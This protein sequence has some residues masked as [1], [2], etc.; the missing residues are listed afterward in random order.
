[1]SNEL[2]KLIAVIPEPV[3]QKK[4]W[5]EFKTL[6][7]KIGDVTGKKFDEN[8]TPYQDLIKELQ[9]TRAIICSFSSDKS[10]IIDLRNRI[11]NALLG[12]DSVL[13]PF[14][15]SLHFRDARKAVM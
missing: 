4:L 10:K 15:S 7:L 6:N 8:Q 2:G 14:T 3:E 11:C 1:M 9:D 5:K 13:Y 12:V